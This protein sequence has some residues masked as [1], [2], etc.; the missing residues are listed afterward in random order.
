[1]RAYSV[2]VMTVIEVTA[3]E[4]L[5]VVTELI[6]S[7]SRLEGSRFKAVLNLRRL[8]RMHER[9]RRKAHQLLA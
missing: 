7:S 1:M 2:T 5:T 4:I 6:P 8:F 9:A 3:A